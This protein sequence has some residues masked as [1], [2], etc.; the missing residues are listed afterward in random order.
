MQGIREIINFWFHTD[1]RKHWFD[2]SEAFD[3]RI[4]SVFA[5]LHRRA[6]RGDLRIWETSAQGCLALCIILD[7]LP[8]NMYRGT[9]AAFATDAEALRVAERAIGL[10][11]DRELD[12]EQKQFL[13][14]PFMH[15]ESVAD[16]LRCYALYEAARLDE[17]LVH[18]KEHLE[19]IRRFGRFPHRNAALG[20]LSS[21][22]ERRFLQQHVGFGQ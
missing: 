7:Q 16:Q 11:F 14:L 20:R 3:E 12:T 18:A 22:D 6:A 15:S 21:E 8:R 13:Y 4:R 2:A 5:P 1:T 9:K 10:G 17:Q 19:I